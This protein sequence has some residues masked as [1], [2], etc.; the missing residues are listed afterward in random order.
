MTLFR[1]LLKI[2]QGLCHAKQ[3]LRPWH[4]SMLHH[5]GILLFY[6][7]LYAAFFSPV[8]LSNR[9]LA[10][11]DGYLQY[12]PAFHSRSTLWTTLLQSGYPIASDPQA[13]SWYPLR[14]L[15]SYFHAWNSFVI[16]AY[17]LSSYFAYIYVYMITKSHF[18]SLMSGIIY[19]MSGFMM[20][21]LGHTT[22]IHNAVWIPLLIAAFE[23]LRH[24]LTLRWFSVASIAV[25][26]SILAGHTQIFIYT[27]GLA[28]TYSVALGWFAVIGRLRYYL[29]CLAILALGLSLSA[30][31]LLPSSE[32]ASMTPRKMLSFSEFSSYSLRLYQVVSL[33]FPYLYGGL[34]ASIYNLP[35]FGEWNG[36][37]LT[38][39][40]GLLPLMT[41][42]IGFI[43]HRS[44]PMAWFWMI[45][46]LFAFFLVLGDA[47]P[48]AKLMYHL[49][50]YNKFR[51]PARHFVEI[52]L[53][54]S[55]LSGLGLT[56]IERQTVKQSLVPTTIALGSVLLLISLIGIFLFQSSLRMM[57]EK[58]GITR[59]ELS[60]WANA[61][62]GVPLLIFVV[63]SVVLFYWSRAPG[64]Y[65]RRI[66][67][68]CV[69]I[70]DLASFGMFYEWRYS[71]QTRDILNLPSY[72]ERYKEVLNAEKQRMLPINGGLGQLTEI[73]PNISKHWGIPSASG[74]GPLILDRI[75]RLL[76]MGT[77][78]GIMGP[79]PAAMDRSLDIL[80]IRYVFLS[81]RDIEP[82][83]VLQKNGL[84]WAAEGL[85]FALGSGCGVRYPDAVRFFLSKP[86]TATEIGIVSAMACS[87]NIPDG[88]PV[89]Q[90]FVNDRKD[91][92]EGKL[93]LAGRDTSEWAYDCDDVLPLMQHR[94]TPIF[95]SSTISR[96]SSRA[97]E[98]HSYLTIVGLDEVEKV[99][100]LE[101]QWLNT[102]PVINVGKISLSDPVNGKSY[103]I[104]LI[105]ALLGDTTRWRPVEEIGETIVYE[106]LRA[107][108]RA[109]LVSDV[110]SLEPDDILNVIKT[111]QLPD[112]RT[113]DPSKT[114]LV[115]DRIN[116]EAHHDEN[117]MAKVKTLTDN[118]VVV[119][120]KSE[121]PAILVLSDT[122]YPGWEATIDG[123]ETDMLR[124]NYVLRAVVLP[125]GEHIVKFEFR[126]KR[127]YVGA[128]I[129]GVA[130]SGLVIVGTFKIWGK[131]RNSRNRNWNG[132]I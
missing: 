69:F 70:L 11:G 7:L 29:S 67:C 4:Q 25:S 109:W 60:P 66:L 128:G 38:G 87:A 73:P 110:V 68:A 28:V 15:F 96:Q 74:Y 53:A 22:I 98:V 61:A 37:E 84:S 10:P 57:A 24:N 117:S 34:P 71:A 45:V 6:S 51:A 103:P 2:V 32:L 64:S 127:F 108:K 124:A 18:S 75:S 49:P 129:T 113:F 27:L 12:L 115:E 63:S 120:T 83:S 93:I 97:C 107:M 116:F 43:A 114:V 58:S 46:G 104:A 35:M 123:I 126:P 95:E 131:M 89:M 23:R 17:V 82:R 76:S 102:G 125:R 99:R 62:I 26:L 9:L 55:V 91:G 16:S 105:E 36:T 50:I 52:A 106:N 30:I 48:L 1:S 8:L 88:T 94:R 14:L 80:A 3:Y 78:G 111:S 59:L 85:P 90:V 19:S 54:I 56:T 100:T 130:V 42:F 44:K 101:F 20:A 13:Q 33:I 119:E 118:I 65:F 40:I 81:R 112:G 77:W 121:N 31:Q 39:Y 92:A 72:A 79:W 41:A 122:S 86:V 5:V 132:F 21:H 47:I